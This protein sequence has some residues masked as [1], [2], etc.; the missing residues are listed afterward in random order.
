MVLKRQEKN[1]KIKAIYSSSNICASTYDK[2]TQAL[3]IIFNNGGQYL[4][5]GVSPTDYTRFEIA[6][7][8]GVVFNSHIKKYPFQKLDKVNVVEILTE[9]ENLKDSEDKI[10]VKHSLNALIDSMKAMITYHES[11]EE[12]EIGQYEK[13][14][15][16][17]EAYDALTTKKDSVNG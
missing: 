15:K 9:V 2:E 5:E 8:Q 3:V 11:T 13:V 1:E 6:D 4:Y 10:K 7:S 12:I 16:S 17:I 14:K